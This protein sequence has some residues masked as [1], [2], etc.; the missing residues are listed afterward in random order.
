M[1]I[2]SEARVRQDRGEPPGNK[3]L[4]CTPPRFSHLVAA[5]G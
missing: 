3:L 1:T 4:P 5:E 2:A